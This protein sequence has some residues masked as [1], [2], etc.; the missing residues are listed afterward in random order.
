VARGLV[1][2]IPDV[3]RIH[4]FMPG[5]GRTAAGRDAAARVM[6][7]M[8]RSAPGRQR[9]KTAGKGAQVSTAQHPVQD[10]DGLVTD[11]AE[12]VRHVAHAVV[13]SADGFAL[14][15]SASLPRGHADQLAAV[16]SGLA[17]LAD[18]AARTFGA[19]EVIQT[20]V[21]MEAGLL[22]TMS[23]GSGST[24]AVLATAECDLGLISC[25]M[26][27]LAERAGPEPAPATRQ[28]YNPGSP[29]PAVPLQARG[30]EASDS[31]SDYC[32]RARQ[33]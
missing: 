4:D 8:P 11:F 32:L 28:E 5:A 17:G 15:F 13:V 24:L 6:K 22:V 23:A 27:L 29:L 30:P 33:A 18:G 9:R 3:A 21:E 31:A 10:L 1:T 12:R 26:S 19:G 20:A 14:A 2:S 25:E 7:E 16:T